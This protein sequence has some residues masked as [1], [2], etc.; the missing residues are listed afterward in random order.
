M[1]ATPLSASPLVVAHDEGGLLIAPDIRHLYVE[2]WLLSVQRLIPSVYRISPSAK[3]S[4]EDPVEAIV[5]DEDITDLEEE[6]EDSSDESRKSVRHPL[7][8]YENRSIKLLPS[9]A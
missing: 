9:R 2:M 3:H 1:I 4:V 6:E 8:S 5:E 7:E